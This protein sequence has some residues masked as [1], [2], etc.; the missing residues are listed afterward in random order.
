MINFIKRFFVDKKKNEFV[1]TL[2]YGKRWSEGYRYIR[3]TTS[4]ERDDIY[5]DGYYRDLVAYA[6][7]V[8]QKGLFGKKFYRINYH[9]GLTGGMRFIHEYVRLKD[10]E[11]IT[12]HEYK[13]EKAVGRA[14]GVS[15]DHT[16]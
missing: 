5:I 9:Q 3:I 16:N 12:E 7:I 4:E 10:A 1:A 6:R 14:T 11:V 8:K 2:K 13:R 15:D